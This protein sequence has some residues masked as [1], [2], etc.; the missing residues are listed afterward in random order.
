MVVRESEDISRRVVVIMLVVAILTSLLGTWT[1]IS[2]INSITTIDN[3]PV[4]TTGRVSL[5]IAP[6][7]NH[8]INQIPNAEKEDLKNE[9]YFK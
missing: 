3:G 8:P 5:T 4:E 1:V 6:N 9:W 7:P 2:A